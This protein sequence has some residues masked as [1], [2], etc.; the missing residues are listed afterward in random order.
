[1][2]VVETVIFR[3]WGGGDFNFHAVGGGSMASQAGIIIFMPVRGKPGPLTRKV[4]TLT[5]KR[6]SRRLSDLTDL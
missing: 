1:M 2:S 4:P 3:Q 5:H 6:L